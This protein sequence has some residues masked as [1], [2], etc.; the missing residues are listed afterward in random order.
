M[1]QCN[2]KCLGSANLFTQEEHMLVLGVKNCKYVHY[3]GQGLHSPTCE[4]M[5]EDQ[6]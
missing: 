2:L 3:S 6:V 5:T 4:L 1:A